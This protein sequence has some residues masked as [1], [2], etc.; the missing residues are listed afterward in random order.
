MTYNNMRLNAF[1]ILLL[2]SFAAQADSNFAF[3][4]HTKFNAVSQSYPD[5]SAL[6]ALFGSSSLDAQADARLNLK[7]R[8]SGWAFNADYQLVGLHSEAIGLGGNLPPDIGNIVNRLP[9]DDRRLFDLTDV[10]SE[11]GDNALL[12]RLDRLW[13]GYSTEKTVIRF[14]RQALSWGN[15]LFYAPMDLVN[16][17]DPA[18][19]DTEYKAGDDMLYVQYLRDS[20]DDVQGAAVIR[21]NLISG[22]V[23]SDVGTYALKY[24]GFAGEYEYD[25]LIAESYA[26]T[27]L[28]LGFGRSVGGAHWGS[29]VVVTNTDD[30]SYFQFVTNLT[31]SWTWRGKNMSG[32]IEYHYNGFGISDDRYDPLSLAQQPELLARIARS[33]MFTLGQHYLAG[34]VMVEMTPLWSITPVLLAN[35]GDPSALL[36]LTTNYSLGDNMTLLGSINLPMGSDGTEFGGIETG[37]PDLYLSTDLGVF[38]QFAWYF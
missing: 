35:V 19:I 9:N 16:P 29:D 37:L 8:S 31:Y 25:V 27:V 6:R 36:Q 30:D 28:G 17:F 22:D 11:S 1:L 23:E 14:G 32:A 21:R 3:T 7:W 26:D 18:T 15:G 33:Q 5:N 4:G 10:I 24:H 20:G 38:A 34:S 2:A 12:H 13:L